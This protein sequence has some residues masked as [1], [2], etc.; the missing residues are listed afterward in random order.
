MKKKQVLAQLG[1]VALGAVLV[2]VP[3][4]VS[5][6]G[7]PAKVKNAATKPRVIDV[8]MSAIAYKPNVIRVA[9]NETV[10]F[11]FVNNTVAPHEALIG[12]TKAQIKHAK[13]MKAA[14][15]EGTDAHAGHDMKSAKGYILVK[16]K[17]TKMLTYTFGKPG[18]LTIGCHQPGHWESGM[19]L[20]VLVQPKTLG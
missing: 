19:K 11:R 20:T 7:E 2:M 15:K 13:E 10:Q 6:A 16:A 1:A 14:A 4:V 17:S 9:A 18:R 5:R 8:E 12:D 3:G